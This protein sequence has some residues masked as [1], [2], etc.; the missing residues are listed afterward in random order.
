MQGRC[1]PEAE[2]EHHLCM[3]PEGAKVEATGVQE[4]L[5]REDKWVAE[6]HRFTRS[7]WT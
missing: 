4:E 6:G 5:N 3:A 2:D 1:H 7:W